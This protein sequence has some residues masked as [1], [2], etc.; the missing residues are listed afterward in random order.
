MLRLALRVLR[1]VL[2]VV[3]VLMGVVML[4]TPGQGI[5]SVLV[6]LGLLEF[7]GKRRV[8]LAI[9]RRSPVRRSIEWIRDRAGSPPL[10]LP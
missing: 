4:F 1:N 5:L 6:G 7:P 8:E 10:E 3:F 2:G 9:A